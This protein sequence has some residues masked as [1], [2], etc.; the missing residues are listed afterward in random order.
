MFW[1]VL[2]IV[3]R[4]NFTMI[5]KQYLFKKCYLRLDRIGYIYVLT[6]RRDESR[7]RRLQA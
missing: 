4:P 1:Y 6:Y 2:N 7:P 3:L 5:V